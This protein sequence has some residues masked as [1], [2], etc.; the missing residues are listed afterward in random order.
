MQGHSATSNLA[1]LLFAFIAMTVSACQSSGDSRPIAGLNGNR[2]LAQAERFARD[3]QYA[4]AA[5]TYEDIAQQGE[6]N[7]RGRLYVRAA[8]EWLRAN[9]LTRAEIALREAA[10]QLPSADAAL[11]GL[12]AGRI[13][14]RR[15]QPA[16][17]LE[18]LDR[19]P[20]PWPR[21]ETPAILELR[22]QALFA[23]G[24]PAG[25]VAAA[26]D[27]E[28]LLNN[29]AEIMNNR[30][31]IWDGVQQS[32][33][34]GVSMLPPAGASRVIAGWLDIG[35]AALAVA[36]NPFQAQGAVD[37]WRANYPAH[38]ANELLTQQVL[39]QVRASVTFPA[40]IALLLP[41]SGNQQMFGEVVR[42][43]FMAA[44]LE[45]PADRRPLI[46]VYD[47]ASGIGNAYAQ[48]VADGARFVVGPLT[49]PEVAALA[50]S[51][52]V[53]I[54][55]LALNELPDQ[56]AT[57]QSNVVP[58]LFR[59]W[60]DPTEEARLVAQRIAAEGLTHGI[61]LLPR[62]DWGERVYR[63]F[64]DE[65]TARGGT[66]VGREFYD[67]T[68]RDFR[69]PVTAALLIDES[70]ARATALSRTLG[71]RLEFEP[72]A[73]KDVQF[74]FLG[75][76]PVQGR[77]LRPTIRF[78]LLDPVPIFAT[79]DIYEPDAAANA[80]IDDVTFPDMPLLIAP[81]SQ[82]I[83]LRAALN[84]HWPARTRER[85]RLYALGYDSFRLV[86]LLVS[87]AEGTGGGFANGMTGRLFIDNSGRV[88]RDLDWARI[89]NG[90]PEALGNA[91][92]MAAPTGIR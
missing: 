69:E 46:R 56:S 7:V 32:A 86:P 6:T 75:A 28:R 91:A 25:A 4:A 10:S 14:L 55:T 89:V 20:Q 81:D 48:A 50:T 47:S 2:Q 34:R 83:Q 35:T 92:V 76:E 79:S 31:M 54:P 68:K 8:R 1:G 37:V 13:A 73:R 43:G 11:Y 70:N 64:A 16:Q 26:V 39:P 77:L 36:R 21:E 27:R 44:V 62:S 66:V 61:A 51:Q 80:D 71:T 53:T 45:Q 33:A 57:D 23:D 85:S 19:I 84:R 72:R 58:N 18:Y 74:I 9:D 3:E 90:R 15:G 88:R 87:H 65:L 41:L 38:P 30:R 59:F 12:V 17:A 29:A 63:A 24:K 40:Q 82:A 78:H 49:K 22:A 5:Q 67:R 52:Q 60:L 42:D